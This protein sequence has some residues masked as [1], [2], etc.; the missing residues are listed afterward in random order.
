MLSWRLCG[1]WLI[2]ASAMV[3]FAG[4]GGHGGSGPDTP[5]PASSSLQAHRQFRAVAG[6]SMGAYGAM[7]IGTKHSDLFSTI[8]ALGGPVDMRQLLR[9][10]VNDNLEVKSQTTIPLNVGDDFTFDHQAPYPGR[11][12]RL[13]MIK[14]LVIAFGNPFLHHPDP[15]RQY[16]AMDSEPARLLRDDVFGTF[17]LPANPRGFLDGGDANQDGVRQTTETPID[18]VDVL[19]LAGGSLP[20]IASGANGVDV[21]GRMLA[22]VNGDGVYDVGDGIVVNLSEPFTD[23]NGNLVFEPEL[24]ETFSDVGLDGVAGTGDYGEG[25]G[26]FDYDPDRANWLAEDP[27][28]RLEARSA[29]DIST[30]RIYMDVG[31]EDQ[32]GFGTHYDNFIAMLQSKGLTVNTRDDFPANCIDIA[33]LPQQ[34]LL[35][36]YVGGHTGIPE[37]DDSQDKLLNGDIC[38]TVVIWQRLLAMISYMDSSF[39]D[40]FDGPGDLSIGDPDPRGDI[41]KTHITSPAL[42]TGS[43]PAPEQPVLIYRPPAYFHTSRSFPIVYILGGYGQAPEDF[44]RLGDMLDPLILTTQMQNM[45]VAV[46]PGAGGRKASFYVN[47]RVPESQVPD[48][49][50][51]TSG[52]YEDSIIQDLIPAIENT[53]LKGR[54]RQ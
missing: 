36:R 43:G 39:P 11:D 32:F 37:A 15:S 24:G 52:R 30:Q 13:S 45:F 1:S 44:E 48:L 54:V 7:N 49:I 20:R 47:H 35:I 5:P 50:N 19:L 40:G 18:P 41:M 8:A 16:L 12:T 29:A 33:K 42:R 23:T 10:M 17:T 51:P 4:C 38:G 21:G 28:T 26:K 31:T 53:I 9:D 25:N 34:Y 22:D 27:L 6:I 46:L 2:G 3:A 14:D